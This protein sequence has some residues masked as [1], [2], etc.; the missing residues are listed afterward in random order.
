MGLLRFWSK[1]GSPT[2][3]SAGPD[4]SVVVPVNAQGDLE[5]V[6]R[7]LDDLKRYRGPHAIE[8]ILVVNNFPDRKPPAAVK[9]LRRMADVV[10]AIPNVRRLGEAIGFS[11]RIPGV[12]AARSECVVL[13][14]ADCR[15][16][17]PTQLLNWY[18]AQFRNGAQAAYT[19]VAYHGFERAPT[20]YAYLFIHHF[21]RWVKRSILGIPTTRGSNYAVRR[22]P[23][24]ELY[25]Q[26]LLA[27]EMNVGPT[28]KRLKGKV[29]YG[30]GRR[31]TVTT[32]GRMFKPG[33]RLLGPYLMYRLRYNLRVLPV[34]P[35]MARRTG[36]EDDPVRRYR[37]NEPI[38]TEDP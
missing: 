14:D 32:S 22:S 19:H 38:V 30:S 1:N 37:D 28:F 13:L 36:R 16:P 21:V 15:V 26:G 33:W 25:D 7:L 5:N 4:A 18:V 11:A 34:R 31:L 29:T 12:R 10:L 2:R 8:T 20:I 24:L 17:N 3:R 6:Q 35:G 9:Q 23:M 27:D